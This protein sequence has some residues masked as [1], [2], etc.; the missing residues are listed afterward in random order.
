[1]IVSTNVVRA[2]REREVD[3]LVGSAAHAAPSSLARSPVG[4]RRRHVHGD[5]GHAGDPMITV[6][7]SVLRRE[8][9][10]ATR[11]PG[12]GGIGACNGS[13]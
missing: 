9:L 6:C 11:W 3:A 13:A 1:M 10:L 8:Q 5:H 4:S 12:R 2:D 7:R